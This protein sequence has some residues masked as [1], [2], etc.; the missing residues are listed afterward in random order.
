MTNKESKAGAGA[1][2]APEEREI[3]TP[4]TILKRFKLYNDIISKLRNE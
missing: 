3:I 2:A 1:G 4:G